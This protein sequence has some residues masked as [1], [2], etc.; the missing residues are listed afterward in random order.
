MILVG[1]GQWVSSK[2]VP[3]KQLPQMVNDFPII[4]TY[5]YISEKHSDLR[6]LLTKVYRGE[7]EGKDYLFSMGR[8]RICE[9]SCGV[10]PKFGFDEN[11]YT[12]EIAFDENGA[13]RKIMFDARFGNIISSTLRGKPVKTEPGPP[14]TNTPPV[15]IKNTW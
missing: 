12:L 15:A 3:I 14:V 10:T 2:P 13:E 1:D 7:V 8:T 11:S 6:I 4:Y 5:I 9:I